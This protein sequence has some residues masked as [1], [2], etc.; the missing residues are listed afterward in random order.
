MTTVEDRVR[1]ARIQAGY[2][3]RQDLTAA[4]RLPR[5]GTQTLGNVERGERAVYPHEADELGRVLEVEAEWLLHGDT[6]PKGLA[7]INA[8][9]DLILEHLGLDASGVR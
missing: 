4:M 6:Q 9:L 5:F 1:A 3:R 2:N 7:A 8:K